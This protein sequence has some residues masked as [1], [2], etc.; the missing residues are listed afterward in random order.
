MLLSI[1]TVVTIGGGGG[2]RVGGG[3]A[4]AAKAEIQFPPYDCGTKSPPRDR[5]ALPVRRLLRAKMSAL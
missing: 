3:E 5:N 2:G 1:A 4:A